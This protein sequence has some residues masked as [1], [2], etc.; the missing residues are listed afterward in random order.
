M[1]EKSGEVKSQ[2]ILRKEPSSSSILAKDIPKLLPSEHKEKNTEKINKFL[3]NI[4]FQKL[5][6]Q[7]SSSKKI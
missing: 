3:R 4:M 6:E 2:L 5:T 7:K 1:E